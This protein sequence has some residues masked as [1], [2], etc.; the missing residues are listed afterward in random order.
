MSTLFKSNAVTHSDEELLQRFAILHE[1]LAECPESFL[2]LFLTST[3][4]LLRQLPSGMLRYLR[5][6][7][8]IILAQSF[9]S[10]PEGRVVMS[11]K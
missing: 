1:V 8:S 9:H 2:Q 11:R 10:N 7:Y 6:D 4:T 5:N 3:L